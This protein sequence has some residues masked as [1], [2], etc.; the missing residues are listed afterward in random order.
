MKT[1]VYHFDNYGF[2]YVAVAFVSLFVFAMY[3]L[4]VKDRSQAATC[5]AHGMVVVRT[6]AGRSCVAPQSLYLLK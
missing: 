4:D 2:A 3:K 6:D 5:Y 1:I